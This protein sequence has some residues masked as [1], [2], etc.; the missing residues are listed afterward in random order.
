MTTGALL[1][2]DVHTW[3]E[4]VENVCANMR[5]V[6]MDLTPVTHVTVYQLS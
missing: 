3:A 1:I 5:N 4:G 2:E 6:T